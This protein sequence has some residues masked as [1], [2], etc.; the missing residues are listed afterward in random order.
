MQEILLAGRKVLLALKRKNGSANFRDFVV[1]EGTRA[2]SHRILRL[3][4]AG[5]TLP[6]LEHFEERIPLVFGRFAFQ[7]V[8]GIGS[9]Q[10]QVGHV[11]FR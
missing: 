6:L 7:R 11:L 2:R 10:L 8:R 4:N 1:Y 9:H 3:S 5:L